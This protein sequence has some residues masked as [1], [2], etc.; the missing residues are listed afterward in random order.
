MYVVVLIVAANTAEARRIS[1]AL[2]S[3]RLA[4]CVNVTGRV[5][6]LFWWKG[7]TDKA[8]EVLMMAK[9]TRAKLPR[10][11]RLVR[12]LHSYDVPEIIA[13][14]IVGGNRDYLDWIDGSIR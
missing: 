7:K 2:V 6:S 11:I 3:S 1:R 8:N 9:S 13:V 5:S 10:I 12:S 14:P 4:A